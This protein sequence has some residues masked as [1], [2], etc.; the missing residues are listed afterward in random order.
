MGV[1]VAVV[2]QRREAVSGKVDTGLMGSVG[3]AEGGLFLSEGL[4]GLHAFD[5]VSRS[6]A[7]TRPLVR[8]AGLNDAHNLEVACSCGLL[9]CLEDQ[10]F[11]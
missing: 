7:R 4:L 5:C 2:G 3:A 10:G 1:L 6:P 9:S 11:S 8:G